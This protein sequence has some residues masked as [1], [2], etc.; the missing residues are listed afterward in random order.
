MGKATGFIEYERQDKP[1]EDPKMRIR[2][3]REFHTPLPKEEQE[4]Q[5]PGV[6]H[7]VFRFVSQVR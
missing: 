4:R 2:H 7:A 5:G 6:W 3:F 1:A